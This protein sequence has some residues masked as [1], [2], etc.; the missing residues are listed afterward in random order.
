MT[1]IQA[2]SKKTEGFVY[3]NLLDKRKK[4]KPKYQIND[5]V[6]TA[7][8]KK[9]FSKSDTTNWSHKTFK[10]TEI[11][12]DT[13]PSYR[14]DNLPERYNESLL[15]ETELTMKENDNVMKKLIIT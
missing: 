9:P 3:K 1:P 7:D 13:I 10:I 15:K 5:L 14:I 4:I 11:I 6:R 8:L 2:S 12:N